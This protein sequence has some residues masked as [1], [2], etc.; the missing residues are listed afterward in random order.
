MDAG[1]LACLL[2]L[3]TMF[4]SFEFWLF[5]VLDYGLYVCELGLVVGVLCIWF[6]WDL[7][8]EFCW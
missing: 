1:I 6:V 2:L 7:W 3:V 5:V 8:S 4:T